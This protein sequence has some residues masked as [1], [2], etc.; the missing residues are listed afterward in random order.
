[1]ELLIKIEFLLII[2]EARMNYNL[3]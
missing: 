3:N 2:I 1:M